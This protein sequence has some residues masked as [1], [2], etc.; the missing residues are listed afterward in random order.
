[1]TIIFE[2][3]AVAFIDILGF[4]N[5]VNDAVA[6]NNVDSLDK[7]VHLLS[8]AVPG[9]NGVVDGSVPKH[10][11]PCHIY[12]SDCIIL[13]API[14]DP[15]VPSY[16]GLS[17]VVMR[18]IQLSHRLLGAGHLIRGGISVGDVWHSA[19][20]IIGP[21]YQEAFQLEHKGQEP[22]VVLSPTAKQHWKSPS[23]LCLDH[24]G[25]VF[26]NSLFA[27]YIPNSCGYGVIEK[28]YKEYAELAEKRLGEGLDGSAKEKWQWFKDF[29]QAEASD[30]Q[31]WKP[32]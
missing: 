12:I 15:S 20:N 32:A 11:I 24:G 13:S 8:S 30:G 7:L 17:T 4:K 19:S 21:A 23:R 22:V 28:T 6:N 31:K 5:F 2:N 29:V 10:L 26:V 18:V 27:D 16:N 1:M 25:E 9:L 3:R 14:S